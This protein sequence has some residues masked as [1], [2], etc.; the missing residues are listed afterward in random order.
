MAFSTFCKARTSVFRAGVNNTTGFLLDLPQGAQ[1]SRKQPPPP[2]FCSVPAASPS[3]RSDGSPHAQWTPWKAKQT[4]SAVDIM[5]G[6]FQRI[7]LAYVR[8]GQKAR[9]QPTSKTPTNSQSTG[10]PFGL[11][12]SSKG[13]NERLLS[14]DSLDVEN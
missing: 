6:R 8:G 13:N 11:P 3:A 9:L 10:I 2:P 4:A 14:L 1:Q 12:L 7:R 5:T